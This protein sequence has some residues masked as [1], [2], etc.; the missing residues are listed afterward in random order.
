MGSQARKTDYDVLIVGS[1]FGGSVTALRLVEKGYKVGILEAGRR[2]EDKDFAKTSWDLKRFLWAPKLGCY[3]IQRVHLLRDCLILAGAGVGGGSLNY[4]NTLYQP[5]EPFFKDK[6][7]AHITDW[8]SELSPFYEQATRMLGV[9]RNPHM[10][11][12][13]EVMKSVAEDMGVGDTFIQ[14]P[15]GVF[16]GDEPGK[17]VA[18]PYFGG[19]GPERTGCIEC[20]ECMTGCR[21]GAKNTLLKNYLA[22]A[23]R[24]GAEIIPMTTVTGVRA[25]P[26]GTWDVATERTG[27]WMRK[28]PT[29]YTAA[30]LVLAAGTWGTQNLLHKMKDEGAL[31]RLSDTLGELTRTNS[32]SIVGAAKMKVDPNVDLTR[33]VAITSSFHP[34]ASTHIEPVRYGKGSNAMGMLQTL[35]TDGGGRI[36]RWL[37]FLVMVVARPLDFV[38]VLNVKNWSERT[39]IALVM[40]NLDNSITTFTK[41]G[42]FGR[43]V[44]SKQGHGEPNP[45]W[46]PEGND[47]TRRIAKKI[48]GI[49]GGTWGE[50]FNI[51]LT[52]HF[53]GGC[54][55]ASDAEHGVIDP[56]HRVYGYPTMFVVDGSSVSANLGVNPSLT[57]SAQAER[58]A[59]LWPNKGEQDLR[60]RQGLPY[61]RIEPI[62]PNN[63]VVPVSAPAALRLTITPVRRDKPATTGAA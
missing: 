53:L 48:G 24:A 42:L 43:T 51:P 13:D 36:P 23:E 35:M 26:D 30:N 11:P 18:D 3:G 44:S 58:S 47:A 33:G 31:P 29:T 34:S 59:A 57:I 1:G 12:A 39:I 55:I 20:G 41:R 38:R 16:F 8:N 14:T 6:Q 63:P 5:P 49:A 22:L 28:R 32:E 10:T 56:Y 50:L 60:P 19:V 7:W 21:H 17:K 2:Y 54:A 25:L 52:A 27:A 45:T 15:V 4:A 46:I 61:E 9:V 37:K 62:A 40:Q